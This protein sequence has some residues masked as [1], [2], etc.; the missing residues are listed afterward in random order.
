MEMS[1]PLES[2]SRAD[3]ES[4]LRVMVKDKPTM[5]PPKSFMAAHREVVV[6]AHLLRPIEKDSQ[7]NDNEASRAAVK[8]LAEEARK[9]W[10]VRTWE[11]ASFQENVARSNR[12]TTR[13]H[14]L[15]EFIGQRDPTPEE[16]VHG[17]NYILAIE[18]GK[19]N[20]PYP[21]LSTLMQTAWPRIKFGMPLLAAHLTIPGGLW[22]L[23][24]IKP[25]ITVH[26]EGVENLPSFF[27]ETVFG[28]EAGGKD[29]SES[30][31]AKRKDRATE[32]KDSPRP[33]LQPDTLSSPIRS[34]SR[35][36]T[37]TTASTTPTMAAPG[38]SSTMTMSRAEN[39][40]QELVEE[41]LTQRRGPT[42]DES[43]HA[44]GLIRA[45]KQGAW[46]EPRESHR[47]VM[48]IASC[49]RD[50]FDADSQASSRSKDEYPRR[51]DLSSTA[52]NQ[53]A[54]KELVLREDEKRN[55]KRPASAS[56]AQNPQKRRQRS[57]IDMSDGVTVHQDGRTIKVSGDN[58]IVNLTGGD[59]DS[60]NTQSLQNPEG[61]TYLTNSAPIYNQNVNSGAGQ[62]NITV[63]GGFNPP[64]PPPTPAIAPIEYIVPEEPESRTNHDSGQQ[65]FI[66]TGDVKN[67]ATPMGDASGHAQTLHNPHGRTHLR[68]T[69]PIYN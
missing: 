50:I 23:L 26:K 20:W 29:K 27:R 66:V 16:K 61:T 44:R 52:A 57:G 59:A 9:I 24:V 38:R 42:R 1:N 3:A 13:M 15:L 65:Q 22:E 69:A 31:S 18:Q 62:Q 39:R 32:D 36:S 49:A 48:S 46:S 17:Y 10:D 14:L 56:P 55:G 6:V 43:S 5:Q 47:R 34:A 30:K 25:G 19:V 60:G 28:E 51:S 37:S 53:A 45:I 11:N 67:N 35:Q 4:M 68:V 21:D 54:G 8:Q 2:F 63:T 12:P 64:P 40:L 58:A 7:E 41:F 33:F